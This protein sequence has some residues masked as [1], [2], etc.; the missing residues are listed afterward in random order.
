M[1]PKMKNR[2]TV[3]FIIL[4]LAKMTN[5][6]I[7]DVNSGQWRSISFDGLIALESIYRSQENYLTNGRVEKPVLDKYA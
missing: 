1:K 4:L 3:F 2:F 5:A 7:T 6:Q